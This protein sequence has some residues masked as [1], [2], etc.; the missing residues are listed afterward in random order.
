MINCSKSLGTV[1][2]SALFWVCCPESPSVLS[3]LRPP[4]ILG[5]LLAA[6]TTLWTED[7]HE[8]DEKF[9]S[10]VQSSLWL[11]HCGHHQ[12]DAQLDTEWWRKAASVAI[13][14]SKF[15]ESSR[16]LYPFLV[17]VCISKILQ[18]IH[19]SWSHP[20]HHGEFLS[21]TYLISHYIKQRNPVSN[22]HCSVLKKPQ[23]FTTRAAEAA[24]VFLVP[25]LLTTG[26]VGKTNTAHLYGTV[27][28]Q[29]F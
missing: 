7:V 26:N 9:W 22:T 17:K 5:N 21:G 8:A 24:P 15:D 14:K 23:Q 28:D 2:V 10:K 11:T 3:T 27:Y 4:I 19:K 25:S 20:S 13:M 12:K 1:P 6:L 16:F 29:M 18:P